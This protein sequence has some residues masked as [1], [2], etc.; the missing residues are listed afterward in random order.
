MSD[1]QLSFSPKPATSWDGGHGL[2]LGQSP[3]LNLDL[4][5]H[6]LHQPLWVVV[7]LRLLLHLLLLL[8]HLP[9][10]LLAPSTVVFLRHVSFSSHQSTSDSDH[11]LPVLALIE[12]PALA[13]AQPRPVGERAPPWLWCRHLE[14]VLSC[15]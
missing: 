4:D 7:V 9:R 11:L 14:Y 1:A 3:G 6:L 2:V 13:P 10:V 5:L 15:R 12:G 8:P